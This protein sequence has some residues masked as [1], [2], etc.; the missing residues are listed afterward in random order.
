MAG[1]ADDLWLPARDGYQRQAMRVKQIARIA[2]MHLRNGGLAVRVATG[3]AAQARSIERPRTLLPGDAEQPGVF[4]AVW[5]YVKW[6]GSSSA[7]TPEKDIIVPRVTPVVI[8]DGRR[9]FLGAG[10]SFNW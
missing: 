10:L 8:N 5:G 6:I 3:M 7:A 9:T 2:G 4:V 1:F